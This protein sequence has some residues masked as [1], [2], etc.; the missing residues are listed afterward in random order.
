MKREKIG[1]CYFR[2]GYGRSKPR[3]ANIYLIDGFAYAKDKANEDTHF[4]PL[5]IHLAG[6]VRVNFWKDIFYQVSDYTTIDK[7]IKYGETVPGINNTTN[8]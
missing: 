5:P 2:T 8:P 6:Y 7:H 3:K 1:T 4:N